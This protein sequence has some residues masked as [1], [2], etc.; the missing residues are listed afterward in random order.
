MKQEEGRNEETEARGQGFL[1][2]V[3]S[4]LGAGMVAGS[5]IAL[6]DAARLWFIGG[7]ADWTIPG[8]AALLYGLVFGLTGAG[9][10]AAL[11]LLGR[12]ARRPAWPPERAWSLIGLALFWLGSM[13]IGFFF[14]HR[15]VFEEKLDL[16]AP[17][18]LGSLAGLAAVLLILCVGLGPAVRWL[19]RRLGERPRRRVSG[20]VV[21]AAGTAILGLIWLAVGAPARS[22]GPGSA[23]ARQGL[24]NVVLVMNDTHRAD[25]TGIYGGPAD[26]TPRLDA[27]AA[28]GVI[29]VNAFAQ[30]SWTR[31]SVATLLTGRYPSSHTAI[32][33]GSVLPREVTTLAEVLQG[34]GYETIGIA[35]NYNLTPFFGFDQGFADYR[36]LAPANPLGASDVQSKLIAIEIAKKLQARLRGN[37]ELP[38]DYYVVAE[39]VTDQA[40]A[41]LDRRDPQ[42][43]FFMF[44]SYMDVHDPYF[45]HPFDGHGIS[46]R[47]NP[48]PDPSLAAEMKELYAGEVRYWDSHFGRLIDGLRERGLYD[49]TL[50]VVTSDHGEEFGE[51]GGFWHGTT[52]YDE[53]LRVIF[54]AKYPAASGLPRGAR[55]DAWIRLLDVSPLI[56]AQMGLAIPQEMQGVAAPEGRPPIFAEVDH[57]GNELSA[58]LLMEQGEQTKLI[59]ANEGNPRGVRPLELYR[60]DVDPGEQS[61]LAAERPERLRAAVMALDAVWAEARKGAAV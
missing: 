3:A 2:P 21:W 17:K 34:G 16:F 56:I 36:Y 58:V 12:L 26:L 52:L 42:R 9:A 10:G 20:I 38:D 40:L 33:K 31:P 54:V 50:V 44:L 49:D 41:R 11:W 22:S 23:P 29:Y 1:H 60:T 48:D 47:S 13:A 46:H 32:L 6:V 19:C 53:Q 39:T 4:G 37:A 18:M 24:P 55:V 14:F 28:D 5:G 30:A 59:R 43:P 57:Q 8:F 45:R 25:H 15:D 61:D 35:T 51:H 7:V 27:L